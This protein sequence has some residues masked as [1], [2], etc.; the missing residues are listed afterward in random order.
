MNILNYLITTTKYNCTTKIKNIYFFFTI[1]II[2]A[3]E[4]R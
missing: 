3:A 1:K 4:N 2:K